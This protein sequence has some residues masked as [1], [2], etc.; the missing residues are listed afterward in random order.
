MSSDSSSLQSSAVINEAV[1]TLRDGGLVAFPTETVYGLG[2]D[3]KNPDAVKRIFTAK[4]RPS[5][6]PLIVHLAAPDRFD[7]SQI[8][9]V[10]VLSP[11]VRDLSEDALRLINAFWPGPLTLV[12]KKDKSVLNELTGGQDTVAIRA[13]AHPIAQELLRKFKGGVVAPSANR[14]GKVSPTSAADVRS[15]FEGMLE[16]M[17]L[18][19]G[20]C[21]VGIESTIIDLSSGEHPV[22]LRPGLITPGE[23]FTKTG[24]KVYLPG[25]SDLVKQ[26]GDAPRVSGSLRAHYAPTTPLR[27]YAPGRVLDALSEFPDIKS[28]VA[29]AVWDSDSSLGDDGHPSAHFEEVI[30][31]SDS[32]AFASRL[33]R[34]LRDLDQQGWDLILFPEPPVGEEWD[35]VRDRLQ[36]A[37]FGS[38][39][40]FNSHAKS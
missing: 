24:I 9:W 27:M 13:P 35:G 29:V 14:F 22:L 39:P 33:Y 19:G 12:F 38:G 30:V 28:R 15:E 34:S 25:E 20:D 21:E 5:N 32:A 6:H 23:I 40:S 4:G 17:I 26:G 3:A 16:L 31:P 7:Q 18:D 36:R 2:A 1:Q 8:D 11:W 37:C 10:P